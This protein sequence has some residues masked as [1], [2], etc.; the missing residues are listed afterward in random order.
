MNEPLIPPVL[1][2]PEIVKIWVRSLLE[3]SPMFRFAHSLARRP[4]LVQVRFPQSKRKRIRRKWAKNPTN[5][6]NRQ[7]N[8]LPEP[9]TFK[10]FELQERIEV[11]TTRSTPPPL[12]DP[13][14]HKK[15]VQ[16]AYESRCYSIDRELTVNSLDVGQIKAYVETHIIS[17]G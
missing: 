16:L 8:R 3:M 15:Q 2:T 12:F 4:D 11:M 17:C 7:T 5:W 9:Q 13:D 10:H 14:W 1:L 6:Q